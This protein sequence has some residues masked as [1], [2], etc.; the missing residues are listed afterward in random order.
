MEWVNDAV[1][2]EVFLSRIAVRIRTRDE[3]QRFCAIL[4]ASKKYH[5]F[6]RNSNINRWKTYGAHI[7]TSYGKSHCSGSIC[8]VFHDDVISFDEFARLVERGSCF[9]DDVTKLKGM[10]LVL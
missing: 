1:L 8:G 2:D 3:W 4:D 10:E 7:T 6:D 5:I 9:E